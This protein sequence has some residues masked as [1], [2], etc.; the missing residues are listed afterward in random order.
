MPNG[1]SEMFSP[2]SSSS[3]RR[4]SG[5]SHSLRPH[6]GS[7]LHCNPPERR[8]SQTT[9]CSNQLMT[10]S[11]FINAHSSRTVSWVYCGVLLWRK[12][13]FFKKIQPQNTFFYVLFW[14]VECQRTDRQQQLLLLL[15]ISVCLR[16]I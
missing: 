6:R 4:S 16:V 11:Q 3:S 10:S 2:V 14:A 7:G 13:R 12:H 5:G 9:S 8:S 15:L 1:T